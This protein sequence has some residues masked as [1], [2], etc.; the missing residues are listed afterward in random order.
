MDSIGFLVLILVITLMACIGLALFFVGYL[1]TV[2]TALGNQHWYWGM[3]IF[4]FG[5]LA[6]PYCLLH[7]QK[8][9]WP[10][11]LIIKGSVVSLIAIAAMA[12]VWYNG[13]LY[14]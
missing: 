9:E 5:L 11:G 10:R 13:V 4:L 1:A 7:P 3:A 14:S 2:A 12:V 8:T 6:I